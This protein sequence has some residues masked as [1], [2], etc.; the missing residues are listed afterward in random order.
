MQSKRPLKNMPRADH[1]FLVE[2][3]LLGNFIEIE[4]P[5]FLRR[6]HD[7]GSVISAEKEAKSPEELETLLAAWFDPSQGKKYPSTYIKMGWG[8]LYAAF[9]TRM[10]LNE[11][12]PCV[13]LALRWGMRHR[14]LLKRE[15]GFVLRDL[16]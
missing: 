6:E 9:A 15:L 11:K 13:G 7:Q 8:Y 1:V 2:L 16:L 10:P 12:V 14:Y 5:L 3:A 4:D